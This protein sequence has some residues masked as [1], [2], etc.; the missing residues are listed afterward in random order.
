MKCSKHHFHTLD[1]RQYK[2]KTKKALWL[3]TAGRG[4][5]RGGG[6]PEWE[7][8]RVEF[9]ESQFS[10]NWRTGCWRGRRCQARAPGPAER[11]ASHAE[12]CCV[13]GC[14][15]GWEGPAWRSGQNSPWAGMVVFTLVRADRPHHTLGIGDAS[16]ESFLNNGGKLALACLSWTRPNSRYS[17]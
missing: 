17:I 6:L 15:G 9:R 1:K 14:Q 11:P 16:E 10:K 2:G 3:L 5:N 7:R 13:C 8:E 12:S 4:W